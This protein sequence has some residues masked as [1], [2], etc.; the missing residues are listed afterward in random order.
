MRIAMFV[1]E[2]PKT[3]CESCTDGVMS[4]LEVF[5]NSELLLFTVQFK[6]D[7]EKTLDAVEPQTIVGSWYPQPMEPER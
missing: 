7:S 4:H 5:Q 6:S 3:I 2:T 1:N